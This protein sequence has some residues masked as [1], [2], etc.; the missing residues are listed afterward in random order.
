LAVDQLDE[1]RLGKGFAIAD[2]ENSQ[3]AQAPLDCIFLQPEQLIYNQMFA[4]REFASQ[5]ASLW[6]RQS[7]T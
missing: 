1:L 4:F 6:Q 5:G 2:G 3:V 7:M